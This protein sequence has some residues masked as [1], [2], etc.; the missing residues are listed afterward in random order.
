MEV[1]RV[2]FICVQKARQLEREWEAGRKG[3]REGTEGGEKD[4]ARKRACRKR[5]REKRARE[6]TTI[7]I[8][9]SCR[10]L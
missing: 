5:E 4:R 10:A 7:K 3:E 8:C 2:L 6:E 9:R 1:G